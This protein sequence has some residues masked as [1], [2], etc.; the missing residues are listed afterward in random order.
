[1]VRLAAA[2]APAVPHA[3]RTRAADTVSAASFAVGCM[4]Y[5][6]L[7]GEAPSVP[8]VPPQGASRPAAP[9][10]HRR[11]SGIRSTVG[12]GRTDHGD[13]RMAGGDGPIGPDRRPPGRAYS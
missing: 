7:M 9:S 5:L 4:S 2:G 13:R 3:A 10:R 6:L 8:R 12:R 11:G 1:M